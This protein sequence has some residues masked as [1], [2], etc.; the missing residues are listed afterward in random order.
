MIIIHMITKI[1]NNLYY[2]K[3]KHHFRVDIRDHMTS[4]MEPISLRNSQIAFDLG[5][6]RALDDTAIPANNNRKICKIRHKK[7]KEESLLDILQIDEQIRACFS[8]EKTKILEYKK[9]VVSMVSTLSNVPMPF[10]IDEKIQDDINVIMNEACSHNESDPKKCC[11]DRHSPLEH[12]HNFEYATLISMTYQEFLDFYFRLK[13]LIV[14]QNNIESGKLENKY[15]EL[16]SH[17]INEYR[18]IL[19]TPVKTSFLSKRKGRGR[20]E[21]EQRKEE[22]VE[23]YMKIACNFVDIDYIPTLSLVSNH[24]EKH[25]C[26]CGNNIDFDVREGSTICEHCGLE[27]ATTSF[28]SNFRDIDRVNTHTKY[29]YNKSSH[30]AEAIAQFQGRQ[31]RYVS[32]DI[33]PRIDAWAKKHNLLELDPKIEEW[34][35]T[36]NIFDLDNATK[37]KR[38]AKFTKDHLRLMFS[39]SKDKSLTDHREDIHLVFSMATGKPC[40][41]ISHL[42][43][44]L[45]GWFDMI[46]NA[47]W[48]SPEIDRTNI[49]N[50][51]FLLAK[52]LKMT[53]YS[54]SQDDFPGLKTLVRQQDHETLFTYLCSKAG[55]NHPDEI[56]GIRTKGFGKKK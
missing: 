12:K 13:R 36:H 10:G 51:Q 20:N 22:L 53:G 32:P 15:I 21:M 19:N 45:T 50:G 17:I 52:F 40:P 47:F 28:Q 35:E 34:L 44:K 55:L 29:K 5:Q 23:S 46:E 43:E 41:D 42:E 9:R 31:N 26:Q 33:Y 48:S 2:Y 49:L 54:V 24:D 8:V 3:F 18:N 37:M 4:S 1:Y 25:T 6:Q 14:K 39:E 16:T 27:V 38:Y 11:G 30:F 7:I 56:Q